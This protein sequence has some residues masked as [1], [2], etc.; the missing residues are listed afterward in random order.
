MIKIFILE[1]NNER[2]KWFKRKITDLVKREFELFI[3][4]DID[5]AIKLYEENKPFDIYFLDHDLGGRVFVDSREENTGYTFAKYLKE[6]NI[7]GENEEVYSH[8]LNP[9]GRKNIINCFK[10][11]KP[12]NIFNF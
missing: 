1:D 2:I 12:I 11:A 10:K 8:S 4:K 7:T 9:I 5:A 6:K 3:S